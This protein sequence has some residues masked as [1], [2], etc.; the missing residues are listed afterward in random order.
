M[1]TI[2]RW[3]VHQ[4]SPPARAHSQ[5][6]HCT[7]PPLPLQGPCRLQVAA[8]KDQ[9]THTNC[10]QRRLGEKKKPLPIEKRPPLSGEIDSSWST[11]RPGETLSSC[12]PAIL[13]DWYPDQCLKCSF[14]A[15][16]LG[17]YNTHLAGLYI[18]GPLFS[19]NFQPI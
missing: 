8:H 19:T 16:D 4:A 18:I 6:A 9:E 7:L 3:P 17:P 12:Q 14:D 13:E 1:V 11:L 5:H 10:A 2:G 15:A